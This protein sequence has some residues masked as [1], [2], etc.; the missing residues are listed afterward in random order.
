[1]TGRH[2]AGKHQPPDEP[3]TRTSD[4]STWR[5]YRGGWVLTVTRL[6]VDSWQAVAEREDTTE[7]SPAIASRLAAQAWA[8]RQAGGAR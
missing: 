1:V 2:A 4:R 5:A 3:W 7:R 8:E 6:G